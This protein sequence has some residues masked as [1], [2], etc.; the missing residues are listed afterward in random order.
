MKPV[1][2]DTA[3]IDPLLP[4][5]AE[6]VSRLAGEIWRGHYPG[7]I[8]PAQI[9]YM[10]LQRYDPA[11][12]RAELAGGE[13]WWYKL[14]VNRIIR[15]FMALE[16]ADRDTMKIDK[17]YVHADE[18]RRGYGARFVSCAAARAGEMDCRRL[19]LA[20]NR[21]N[22]QAI[23]AYRKYGFRISESVVKDISGGFVMD[24][25]LMEKCL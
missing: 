23:A 11:H 1:C 6:T 4:G 20:V 7:I 5:D 19:L 18:Q 17:L 14:T 25:Y 15:G 12:I 2:T 3:A 9:D 8:P 24:D 21:R 16:R 22:A 13:R 10:L